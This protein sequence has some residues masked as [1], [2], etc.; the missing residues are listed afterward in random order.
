MLTIYRWTAHPP[1]YLKGVPVV[2]STETGYTDDS[3]IAEGGHFVNDKSG[4]LLLWVLDG[5]DH[6]RWQ[7][8]KHAG[9]METAS[10]VVVH[11]LI[12]VDIMMQSFQAGQYNLSS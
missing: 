6:H 10:R 8:L 11:L 7:Y 5:N 9:N 2:G 12:G 4:V 1:L 3:D